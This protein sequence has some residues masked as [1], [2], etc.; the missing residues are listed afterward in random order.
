MPP[1][2]RLAFLAVNASYSHTNLA[3]WRLHEIAEAKGWE[4]LEFET[5]G[6]SSPQPLLLQ[7]ACARP[8]LVAASFYIFN[9]EW[10]LD[11]F[12]RLRKLLP[13]CLM[14]GGGPEFLGDNADFF[15][16]TPPLDLVMRGEGEIA[17]AELLR[18]IEDRATWPAIAGLCG[19]AN[20]SY[21]DAGTAKLP[22]ITALPQPYMRN[23]P[24]FNKPF[25]LME[26]ARGCMNQCAF[27]ASA[28]TGPL[29]ALRIE[30]VRRELHTIADAGIREVRLADRT[31][32]E[33]PERCRMFLEL[34][35]TEFP[36]IRFHLEIEPARLTAVVLE[37]MALAQ[38]GRLHLEVG[39]QC[40]N[41]LVLKAINRKSAITSLRR[42]LEKLCSLPNVEAHVDLLAGL[43]FQTLADLETDLI[44]LSRLGPA[45]IQL[46]LLKLLPGTTLEQERRKFGLVAAPNPPY[47]ILST[48]TMNKQDLAL[49][50]RLAR[51]IDGIYNNPELHQIIRKATAREPRLW[52]AMAKA[53]EGAY[54]SPQAG[55]P[56][57]QRFRFLFDHL[58][59]H[60]DIREELGI[61]WLKH[62][63][64]AP[65][66]LIATRPWKAPI[67]QEA[68]LIEG[69]S[70]LPAARMWLADL[71]PP[72]LFVFGKT[73]NRRAQA[74]YQLTQQKT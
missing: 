47:Q 53:L 4:W 71:R 32:N 18:N 60:P 48:P 3:A 13:E 8:R 1:H 22:D 25:L 57:E 27:C 59:A 55:W 9:R 54:C 28:G 17:F 26:T 68:V 45:E 56:L 10:L 24:G 37:E 35:R 46:E 61:I 64:S 74:V 21:F 39:V 63:F 33:Q 16:S 23:M 31:F 40:M 6:R 73:S 66:G 62:G 65:R 58:E 20:G 41:P 51:L 2:P 15:N 12:R 5:T 42:N 38:A 19:M 44:F 69:D 49:A 43:P 52:I 14:L 67:P 36:E 70:T 34:F 72:L 50:D 7:I 29:R 11:F 30:Q